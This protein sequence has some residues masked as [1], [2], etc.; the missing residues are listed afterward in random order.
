MA[1]QV[2]WYNTL[3][4]TAA[5][6]GV[7]LELRQMCITWFRADP[8]NPLTTDEAYA[9]C[10]LDEFVMKIDTRLGIDTP[11]AE[12]K[13]IEHL[14]TVSAA[15]LQERSQEQKTEKKPLHEV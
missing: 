11:E 1:L 3:L 2:D 10:I 8:H 15:V 13:M 7:L 14:A 6:R 4:S 12:L 5:G 9:Q